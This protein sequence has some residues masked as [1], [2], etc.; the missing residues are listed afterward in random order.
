MPVAGI[1]GPPGPQGPQGPQ[2]PRGPQGITGSVGPTGPLG[3]FARYRYTEPD[4]HTILYYKLDEETAAVLD[5]AGVSGGV[6][7][8]VATQEA[9]R[10]HVDGF[11]TYAFYNDSYASPTEAIYL[12]SSTT[13]TGWG[14]GTVHGWV[15][16]NT[17]T[18]YAIFLGSGVSGENNGAFGW[19]FDET[20]TFSVAGGTVNGIVQTTTNIWH[21]VAIVWDGATTTT[22]YIDAVKV[23][24]GGDPNLFA[25]T[26]W[27]CEFLEATVCDLRGEDVARSESYIQTLYRNGFRQDLF[28]L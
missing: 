16:L 24:T 6:D 3:A 11:F 5:N 7:A 21:H 12:V 17:D 15:K 27:R 2:G 9:T 14:E 18:G 8:L 10:P 19:R 28:T 13:G 4:E 22:C 23:A 20:P 26:S 25:I 1:P